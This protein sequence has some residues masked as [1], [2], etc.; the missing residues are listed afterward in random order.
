MRYKYMRVKNNKTYLQFDIV[1]SLNLC[2]FYYYNGVN[3]EDN[4]LVYERLFV[5][6]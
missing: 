3:E 4:L 1:H 5:H 2:V 6:I